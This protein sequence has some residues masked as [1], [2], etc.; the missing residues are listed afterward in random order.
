MASQKGVNSTLRTNDPSDKIDVTNQHARIRMSYDKVTL[1]SE[2]S[3][4]Q[5]LTM[6][7]VPI[8]AKIIESTIKHDDL[9]TTGILKM[10]V[11][12]VDLITGIDVK[13][14]AAVQKFPTAFADNMPADVA[15][16]SDILLEA[17]EATDAGTG[18]VVEM[19]TKYTLD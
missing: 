8:G 15:A 17:T 2:L 7:S 9:G 5:T 3:M 12:G 4:G 19:W 10:V 18:K 11:N 16:E 6:G 14:A 1:T 13:A